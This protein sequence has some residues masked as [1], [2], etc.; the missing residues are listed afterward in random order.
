MPAYGFTSL[1]GLA[2]IDRLMATLSAISGRPVPEKQR[3]WREPADGR[4]GGQPLPVRREEG[5]A[6][7]GGGPPEGDGPLPRGDGVRDPGGH[8]RHPHPR[9]GRGSRRERLRR[10]PG[11]PGAAGEGADLLVANSNGRQ[12]AAKLGIK[13]HLRT[14]MPVFDRLGAHQK[15]WVGY[16]GTMNLVFEVAN[17]SRQMPRRRRSWRTTEVHNHEGRI[18]QYRRQRIDEH[19]GKASLFDVWEIGPDTAGFVEWASAVTSAD[20]EE[21]E[22]TARAPPSPG[23]PSSTRCKWAARPR[24]SWWPDRSTP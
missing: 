23:A 19:F 18:H 15:M 5:G 10:R 1:T 13:A 21:D 17:C 16:R 9:A 8:R 12:A 14:G 2:E 7:P 20:D 11:G 6:G 24:P 22:S 4:H 3:R